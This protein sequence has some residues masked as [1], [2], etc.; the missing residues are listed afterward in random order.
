MKKEETLRLVKS[1][2]ISNIAGIHEAYSI[3]KNKDFYLFT[4]N[5]SAEKIGDLFQS[6]AKQV[7]LPA[8]LII[9]I[10]TREDKET[11][12]RKSQEDQFHK[13]VF[14]LDKLDYSYF[15]KI[16]TRYKELLIND[17]MV[18]FGFSSHVLTDEVYVGPY[19]IFNIFTKEPGKYENILRNNGF[20]KEEKIM[21]LCDIVSRDNP[22]TRNRI[23]VDDLDIYK[24][25]EEL[26]QKGLCF[27]ETMAEF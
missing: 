7:C 1:I 14:Y 16:F 18:K 9:E 15:L 21:T 8:F 25:V 3:E 5:V 19:K 2:Q 26:K 17:S 13:D 11:Q 23:T 12:L 24:L 6:L 27:V 20:T 4:I 10:P 22:A